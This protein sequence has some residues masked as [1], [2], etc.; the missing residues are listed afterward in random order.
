MNTKTLATVNQVSIMLMSENN[1]KLVPIKP[2]CEALGIDEDAQRRKLKDDDFLNSVTVLSTATGA[3]GKQYEMVCLPFEFIFG[4]LFTINPKNVKEESRE[5]VAKYRI[6]CYR[7]L[8]YHFASQSEFLEEKQKRIDEKI[9]AYDQLRE[10]FKSAE[11]NLKQAKTELYK[12]KDFTY[13]DWLA[14][15][16]QMEINFTDQL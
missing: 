3:D 9:I 16:Q 5:A 10:E 4:W 1:Q 6:E 8:F 11:K 15:K 13:E 12:A 7:A 2:I 14:S